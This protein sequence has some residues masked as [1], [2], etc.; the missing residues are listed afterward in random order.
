[1]LTK[2]FETAL[3]RTSIFAD[4]FQKVRLSFDPKKKQI[5]FFARNPDLGES[6]ESIPANITGEAVQ[7]SFNY[8]YLASILSLTGAESLS[9]SVAGIGRPLILKGVGDTSLLYLV[10]PMNQ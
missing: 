3:K 4:S 9:C 6:T 10:S 7:I 1:M 8:R 2:D 5:A